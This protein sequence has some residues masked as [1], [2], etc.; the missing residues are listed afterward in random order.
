MSA[1]GILQ[2][3]VSGTVVRGPALASSLLGI[4]IIGSGLFETP[5]PP[6]DDPGGHP[7]A[8]VSQ[9]T[10]VTRTIRNGVLTTVFVVLAVYLAD[11][12]P[13]ST[14]L[15]PALGFGV[16]AAGFSYWDRAHKYH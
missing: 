4:G 5:R 7:D 16:V 12:S 6:R 15:L 8:L 14:S 1:Y 11:W 9:R 13:L 3:A 10:R 2:M